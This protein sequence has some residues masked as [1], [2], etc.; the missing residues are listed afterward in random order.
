MKVIQIMCCLILVVTILPSETGAQCKTSRVSVD[1]SGVQGNDH[2]FKPSVSTDG[3]YTAYESR[4][5]NLVTGDTNGSEDIFIH[6]RPSGITFRVSVDST[7]SQAFGSS[8]NPSISAAGRY[9]A[10]QSS[11]G[12]LVPGDTNM[13]TDIFV[14]DTFTGETTRVSVSS[15][16]Q[17]ANY[18]G[19]EASISADGRHVAFQSTATNLVPGAGS[20]MKIFVHD[21]QTGETSLVSVDSAGVSANGNCLYPSISPDGRYVAFESYANALVP[22]DTNNETDIFVHD[23]QTGETVRASVSST[24]IEGDKDSERAAMADDGV[25]AF[26]SKAYN[27]VPGIDPGWVEVYVHDIATGETKMVSV[28]SSGIQG[29]GYSRYPS[30]SADGRFVTFQSSSMMLV[31][32]E[33]TYFE[34]IFHHDNQTGLTTKVSLDSSGVQADYSSMLEHGVSPDGRSVAFVSGASNLVPGDTNVKSDIFLR[35]GRSLEAEANVLH[36][37]GGTVN[38]TV[39]A[40]TCNANRNYLIFGSVSS[41]SA[42]IWL[43]GNAVNLPLTWD[44]FTDLVFTFLN[45]PTFSGFLGKL[46]ASGKSAAQLNAPALP[47]ACEDLR[48][49]FAFCLNNPFDYA[50]NPEVIEIVP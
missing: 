8:M 19:A 18:G 23:R 43:P 42:G 10:F 22:N 15:S 46:N 34:D 30:I 6:E 31:P 44:P 17:Q 26:Q 21:R 41:D 4:A 36:I 37:T 25:V 14:H 2:S 49:F 13:S 1:T 47:P 32:G 45:M 39:D 11:A 29:K 33:V 50:S 28:N 9:V 38:L 27:L 12:N 20:L 5:S 24:G 3:L 35:S 7:G 40:D 48:M 16:G